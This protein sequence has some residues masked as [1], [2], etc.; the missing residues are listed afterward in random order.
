MRRVLTFVLV[1]PLLAA[2]LLSLPTIAMELAYYFEWARPPR[3][4]LN[5]IPVITVIV[6]MTCSIGSIVGLLLTTLDYFLNRRAFSLTW[7]ILVCTLSPAVVGIVISLLFGT[8]SGV[9]ISV[10]IGLIIAIPTAGCFWLS[11]NDDWQ[12]A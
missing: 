4:R 1:G 12:N 10:W 7:R 8:A 3:K 9:A 6:V 2:L 5:P 11:R